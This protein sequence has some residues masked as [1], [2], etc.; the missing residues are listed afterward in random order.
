MAY[1]KGG[2]WQ[3]G[4][5]PP[6]FGM[7]PGT[8]LYNPAAVAPPKGGFPPFG[9]GAAP[10]GLIPVYHGTIP[11]A[12]QPHKGVYD[13]F[14]NGKKGA[15]SPLRKGG[16]DSAGAAG[17]VHARDADRRD[18]D[19]DEEAAGVGAEDPDNRNVGSENRDSFEV[20]KREVVLKPNPAHDV[21]DD[22]D[23]AGSS[24][25][26][27]PPGAK[28]VLKPNPAA[29]RAQER[30]PY[31]AAAPAG[32]KKKKKKKKR[33]D[34]QDLDEEVL[35]TS[36]EGGALPGA[37]AISRKDSVAAASSR[38]NSA[39]RSSSRKNSAARSPALSPKRDLAVRANS[40]LNNPLGADSA[41]NA[42]LVFDEGEE[43]LDFAED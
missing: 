7:P 12:Q 8:G 25:Q 39:A 20:E 36:S 11:P 23:G 5:P 31:G 3:K 22:G 41:L 28:V 18:N 43:E 29:E 15:K 38:K 33:A 42:N 34:V 35:S 16:K 24:A 14:H 40:A 19:K 17:G 10:K 21:E 6:G 27:G 32:K 2:G 9:A 1:W 13:K 26:D 37:A 30:N 4:I